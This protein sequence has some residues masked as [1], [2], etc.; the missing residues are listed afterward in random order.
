MCHGPPKTTTQLIIFTLIVD[1]SRRKWSPTVDFQLISWNL[2]S[3]SF[4][5]SLF[6]TFH[7]IAFSTEGKSS[8]GSFSLLFFFFSSPYPFLQSVLFL[9]LYK[10]LLLWVFCFERRNS[11]L[12]LLVAD[13]RTRALPTSSWFSDLP[14][15]F[16]SVA[17]PQASAPHALSRMASGSHVPPIFRLL[18]SFLLALLRAI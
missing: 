8:F 16:C 14:F 10:F 4:L 18:L 2:S 6:A 12:S 13:H 11:N 7:F 15:P 17:R 9:S 3:F 5:F 1:N